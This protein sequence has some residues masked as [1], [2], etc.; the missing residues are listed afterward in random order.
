MISFIPE[1]I[2]QIK[3]WAVKSLASHDLPPLDGFSDVRLMPWSCV[4]RADTERG[5][6]YLKWMAP[7]FSREP[8]IIDFLKRNVSDSHLPVV[9]AENPDLSAFIMEDAGIVL[10]D[11]IIHQYDTDMVERVLQTYAHFQRRAIGKTPDLP[12]DV[13][14][15]YRLGNL[16]ELF[17]TLLGKQN[18]LNT[19]GITNDMIHKLKSARHSFSIWCTQLSSCGIPDTIEHGDFHDNNVLIKDDHITLNDWGDCAWSHP[20]LSAATFVNSAIKRGV[21]HEGDD[22]YKGLRDAYLYEWRDYG[23]LS[24]LQRGFEVSRLLRPFVFIL[25]LQRVYET[26]GLE[27]YPEF[28]GYLAQT[29]DLLLNNLNHRPLPD[30]SLRI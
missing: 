10:R 7:L 5:R 21:F 17:D 28:H 18:F 26:P 2:D 27:H 19:H 9:L 14:H 8:E 15:D 20:F 23:D 24:S 25:S 3:S 11:Q 6:I 4:W 29:F 22:I 16:P 30:L 13:F 1:N 12:K